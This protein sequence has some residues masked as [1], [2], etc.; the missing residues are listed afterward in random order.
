MNCDPFVAMKPPSPA[1]SSLSERRSMALSDENG[2][3]LG[4][5][6]TQLP[7]SAGTFSTLT[8]A[9]TIAARRQK[10]TTVM[11]WQQRRLIRSGISS[12]QGAKTVTELGSPIKPMAFRQFV[13]SER[14][15]ESMADLHSYLVT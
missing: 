14:M 8:S 3:G 2:S 6:G 13:S 11:H 4:L 12:S 5:K 10:S 15:L 7:S 9:R 1:C